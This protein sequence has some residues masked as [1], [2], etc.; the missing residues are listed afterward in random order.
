MCFISNMIWSCDSCIFFLRLPRHYFV[1]NSHLSSNPGE[2]FYMFTIIAAW[3]INVAGRPFTEPREHD[4]PNATVSN[5][6]AELR[7]F[8]SCCFTCRW[9]NMSLSLWLRLWSQ[10]CEDDLWLWPWWVSGRKGGLPSLQIEDGLRRARLLG[11]GPTGRR[12]FEEEKL[13]LQKVL[14]LCFTLGHLLGQTRVLGWYWS[15]FKTGMNEAVLQL[16]GWSVFLLGSQQYRLWSEVSLVKFRPPH[17]KD[18]RLKL[19]LWCF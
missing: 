3:L 12:G 13:L 9:S 16:Q 6:L 17:L 8:V 10:M 15:Q 5:I 14:L 1:S 11:V 19:C 4:E 18:L 7:A 2:Q